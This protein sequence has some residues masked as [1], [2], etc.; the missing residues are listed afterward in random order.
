ML[1]RPGGGGK[2]HLCGD[3][4]KNATKVNGQ[5]NYLSS[6]RRWRQKY[7]KSISLSLPKD[8]STAPLVNTASVSDTATVQ[9]AAMFVP[10]AQ[11]AQS[12]H[13]PMPIR[14]IAATWR[15]AEQWALGPHQLALDHT[16]GASKPE[17]TDSSKAL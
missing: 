2:S 12:S 6:R 17:T 8:Y 10:D 13:Y 14:P 5:K 1:W 9:I 3:S 4:C 11:R 16:V 7:L 15:A